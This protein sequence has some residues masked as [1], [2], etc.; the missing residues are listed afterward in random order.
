MNLRDEASPVASVAMDRDDLRLLA[1]RAAEVGADVK[2]YL[3][4]GVES[5]FD[6]A[7][8]RE[9]DRESAS[10]ER[11]RDIE[12]EVTRRLAAELA[13]ACRE[14]Q[15]AGNDRGYGLKLPRDSAGRVIRS[16]PMS[17]RVNPNGSAGVGA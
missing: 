13:A 3:L 9:A 7:V 2:R 16:A 5:A 10:K 8:K 17:R 12:R 11:A 4:Q 1:A 6:L 15:S 14:D